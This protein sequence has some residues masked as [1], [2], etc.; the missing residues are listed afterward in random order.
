MCPACK[1]IYEQF[2]PG[3]TGVGWDLAFLGLN[4]LLTTGQDRP[5]DAEAFFATPAAKNLVAA[6]AKA[7]AEAVL[8]HG[9]TP[10][11]TRRQEMLDDLVR[12]VQSG[13][14]T[15]TDAAAPAIASE[16]AAHA[17]SPAPA[18]REWTERIDQGR[19][20]GKTVIVTG[21]GSGIGRATASR[22]AREG[23]RVIAV[24]TD[25]ADTAGTMRAAA[26]IRQMLDDATLPPLRGLAGNAGIQ[27]LDDDHV[28]AARRARGR[29]P[30]PW[31]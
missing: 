5:E 2:G 18:P 15:Q 9:M 8:V 6:A 7:W 19:F 22:I 16:A 14:A 4:A 3:A 10:V 27:Y 12:R 20:A 30:R 25:L 13:D 17:A 23:G 29:R 21:A 28:T 31:R 11:N 26:E 1:E 24:D